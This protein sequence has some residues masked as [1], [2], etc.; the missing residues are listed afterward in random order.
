MDKC[1]T[2]Q[3]A[4]SKSD[5]SS[6]LRK[7]KEQCLAQEEEIDSLVGQI[8][9][10]KRNELHSSSSSL[11]VQDNVLQAK[12]MEQEKEIQSLLAKLGTEIISVSL[13][14]MLAP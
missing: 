8:E 3:S 14:S 6:E 2:D 10:M 7:F 1:I 12:C 9:A 4:V 11:M 5:S 13:L